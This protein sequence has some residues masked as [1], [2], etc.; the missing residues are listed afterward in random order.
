MVSLAC[1]GGTLCA[2]ASARL[3]SA[4]QMVASERHTLK[5]LLKRARKVYHE[6][7]DR[8]GW[9]TFALPRYNR[10]WNT[11]SVQA[12]VRGF[13]L[14]PAGLD[15]GVFGMVG[16]EGNPVRR[17]WRFAINCHPAHRRLNGCK[18]PGG[19]VHTIAAGRVTKGTDRDPKDLALY[20]HAG[21]R[22]ALDA[23]SSSTARGASVM[24]RSDHKL[25]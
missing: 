1:T 10:Y 13:G 5:H 18:C 7:G 24:A 3:S 2:Y 6:A 16:Q 14:K 8:G 12:F 11:D 17:P 4:Y 9:V 23:L 20:T 21:Y 19:R 25:R 15:R 22:G